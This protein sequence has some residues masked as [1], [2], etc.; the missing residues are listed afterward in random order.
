MVFF[1]SFL[2]SFVLSLCF[3]CFFTFGISFRSVSG[4]AFLRSLRKKKDTVLLMKKMPLY[5]CVVYNI[6]F[7]KEKERK[8]RKRKYNIL[9]RSQ[10]P[11]QDYNLSWMPGDAALDANVWRK[12]Q[13][14]TP[15]SQRESVA[16]WKLHQQWCSQH[17]G[18]KI[19]WITYS[20][21]PSSLRYGEERVL[22]PSW[23]IEA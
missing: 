9:V 11:T 2:F 15:E 12:Y 3:C 1:F 22:Y 20:P 18:N 19:T 5:V 6:L 13:K 4:P 17:L 7:K 23:L 14:E 16:W 21:N 8:K 10:N